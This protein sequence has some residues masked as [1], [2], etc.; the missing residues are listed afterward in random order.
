MSVIAAYSEKTIWT[1][2]FS[3]K[4]SDWRMWSKQFLAMSSKKKYNSVLLGTMTVPNNTETLN[5]A[6]SD[7]SAET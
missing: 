7:R 4:K 3:G 2:Q 6:E 5:A 1:V